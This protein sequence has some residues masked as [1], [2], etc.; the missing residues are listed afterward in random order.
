[1]HNIFNIKANLK[2]HLKSH[3]KNSLKTGLVINLSLCLLLG[4]SLSYAEQVSS[5]SASKQPAA[6]MQYYIIE[7]VLFRQLNEQGMRDEYWSRPQD[8]GLH[9]PVN[10]L[11]DESP[12]LAEYNLSRQRLLPLR[13]GIAAVSAAHYRLADSAAQLRYSPDYQVLA[14]FGWTQRSLSRHRALPIKITSDNISDTM[15]PTGELK[16]YVTRFLHLQVDLAASHC[17][18]VAQFEQE[19]AVK[20]RLQLEE[21]QPG[22]PEDAGQDKALDKKPALGI[23]PETVLESETLGL[24]CINKVYRFKQNRKMRSRELH[25]LDNP[26]YGL[27]VYVTP[28]TAGG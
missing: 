10:T 24:N 20:N 22:V 18:P 27:L 12:A 11:V 17:Q 2:S 9:N 8:Q 13:N 14:H 25:Y 19:Q 26:V 21:Q 3:L 7:V 23:I 15:L 16:L 5:D 6:R 4:T 28:F 1:M